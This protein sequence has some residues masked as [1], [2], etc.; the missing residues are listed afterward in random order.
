[1]RSPGSALEL[2]RRRQLAV[3]RVN[4]GYSPQQVAAFLGGALRHGQPLGLHGAGARSRA[5][6][7]KPTRGRP[8]KLTARQERAVLGWVAKPPTQFGFPTDLWTSRR[9]AALIEQR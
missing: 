7:A 5:L 6:Q 3:A 8:R 9:L 1:M 2:E 4:E